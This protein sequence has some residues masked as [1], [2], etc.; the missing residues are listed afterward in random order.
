MV[1]WVAEAFKSLT[2]AVDRGL[3]LE[4]PGGMLVPACTPELRAVEL[5]GT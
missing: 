1:L 2:G 4:L 3:F 5:T